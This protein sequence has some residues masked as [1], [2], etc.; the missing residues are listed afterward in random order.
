[1]PSQGSFRPRG[2]PIAP[3]VTASRRLDVGTRQRFELQALAGGEDEVVETAEPHKERPHRHLVGKIERINRSS[4]CWVIRRI[5]PCERGPS[6]LAFWR[7]FV[8]SA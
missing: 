2:H 4:H 3:V 1:M 7:S 6:S 8:Q 5:G